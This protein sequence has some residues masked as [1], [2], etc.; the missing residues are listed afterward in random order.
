MRDTKQG[1]WVYMMADRYRG[2]LYVGVTS[3]LP[4]RIYQHRSGTGSYF[5]AKYGLSRLVWAA[6]GEDIVSC[7][8]QE[9]RIKRWR[10]Q[11]KFDLIERGNPEWRDLFDLLA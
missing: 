5:C 11:W 4:A 8:A 2:T 10:R 9:K 7:I 6:H 1:G 3:D